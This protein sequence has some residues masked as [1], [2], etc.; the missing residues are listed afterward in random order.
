VESFNKA[1]K[2][3]NHSQREAV[4]TIYGPVL[5]IAGPG[6]GKTQLISTRVGHILE[7]TDTLPQNIL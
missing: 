2:E 5:V 3:L 4:D 1:Y 6:T 7:A